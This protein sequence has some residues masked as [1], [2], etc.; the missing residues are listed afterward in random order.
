VI[1]VDW[2]GKRKQAEEFVW[3]AEVRDVMVS[4]SICA[5]VFPAS[6]WLPA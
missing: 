2:S 4:S 5:M 6:S 1:A 3:F